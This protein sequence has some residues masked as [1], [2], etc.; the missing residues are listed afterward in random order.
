MASRKKAWIVITLLVI[1][2]ALTVLFFIKQGASKPEKVELV[3][4]QITQPKQESEPKAVT[5]PEI[6]PEP[7]PEPQPEPAPEPEP[8]PETEPQPEPEPEPEPEIQIRVPDAPDLDW[9]VITEEYVPP[10]QNL[11]QE[12]ENVDWSEFVFSDQEVVLPNGIYYA[13][14]FVNDSVMGTIEFEQRDSNPLFLRTDLQAMLNGTLSE[15]AFNQFFSNTNDRY[16]LQY[17]ESSAERVT[18]NST[19]LILKLYFNSSQ[20]PVQTISM[21]S[22]SFSSLRQNYD[23]VGNVTVNPAHFS[24]VSNMSLFMSMMYDLDSAFSW[25]NLNATLSLANTFSF[26]NTTFSMPASL[27]YVNSRGVIPSIGSWNAYI[28]FPNQNIRFSFGNVGN[29][30]FT[31]GTPVGFTVEKNYGFGTGSAMNNQFAQTITLSEDSSVDISVNG[32]SVFNRNLSLGIYRLTDFAFVQGSNDVVVTIHPLSR[33]EDTSEDKII[34]FGQNY[35]TSLMAKGETTW[36]TGISIPKVNQKLGT[37]GNYPYGFI[38]PALP[39][40]SSIDGWT[41]MENVY[42]LSA[43]SIFWEQSIGLTH[44]YTQSHSFSFVYEKDDNVDQVQSLLF[45]GTVSGIIAT[46]LG[47][48][49]VTLNGS[50]SNTNASRTSLS[51]AFS[52]SFISEILKPLSFS[53]SYSFTPDVQMTSL[54]LG[55]SFNIKGV[56]IGLSASSSYKFPS[57]SSSSSLTDPLSINAALSVGTNLGKNGAFSLNASINQSMNVYATASLSFSYSGQSLS[58]SVSTSQLKT[59]VGNISWS[60]RPGSTSR[61]S[62]QLNASNIDLMNLN[63]QEIPSHTLSGAWARSGDIVS[64]SLRAQA[65]NKYRRFS[66][67]LSLNTS[68]V[69]ADGYFSMA[70]SVYGP[71]LIVAPSKGLKNATIAVS[72]ATESSTGSSKKVFGNVLYTRLSMY[73]PNNVIVYAS[74]GSLF[75]SSGSFLFKITPV[76]RQGFLAK[77]SLESTVAISGVLRQDPVTVY[78]SYSSPIYSVQLADNGVDVK[79]MEIESSSYFFTDVDGRFIISDLK[80][81]IYMV[82]LNING[83]W[84]AAFFE[85]PVVEKPGYVAILKDFDASTVDLQAQTMQK[86]N[87]KAFDDSYAGSVYIDFDKYITEDEYWSMLFTISEENT[88]DWYDFDEFDEYDESLYKDISAEGR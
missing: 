63:F 44:T 82:D 18:Y 65:S 38:I 5:A 37:A 19:D 47:T 41:S 75:T 39:S 33:G 83:Q 28:D 59:L 7:Q 16:T 66:S 64:M 21:S 40:Y 68:L 12:E 6:E 73:K 31:N 51:L 62:F 45:G 13:T 34:R 84:Y 67:S 79:S 20:V 4:E 87:V 78:D 56:R 25:S 14:L 54:N 26:W 8:Q 3:A 60:F 22:S 76:A 46:S 9:M 86:Y 80:S 53:C 52:Q 2:V 17:L 24:F 27:T 70:N 29:A 43:I 15:S 74:N 85:V 61:S 35:D 71:F 11:Y 88:A 77:I 55:Y 69:F 1:A 81:G 42:N 57:V 50:F 58:S 48:S 72:N 23:V 10:V 49:R 30:G 36:R 32:N